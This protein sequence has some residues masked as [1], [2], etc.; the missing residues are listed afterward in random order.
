MTGGGAT[1]PGQA[2]RN[3]KSSQLLHRPIPTNQQ[4][5]RPH[6]TDLTHTSSGPSSLGRWELPQSQSSCTTGSP[7]LALHPNRRPMMEIEGRTA[8]HALGAMYP[9]A[10]GH[11][12]NGQRNFHLCRY[13]S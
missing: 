5:Q 9:R 2:L 12:G 4:H 13:L 11:H 3:G 10:G 1:R 7:N 6:A 8:S